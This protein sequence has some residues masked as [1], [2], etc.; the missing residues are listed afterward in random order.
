M[1]SENPIQIARGLIERH[2]SRAAAVAQ[3]H[4]EVARMA[5]DSAELQR[6]NQVALAV[7]QLR[8]SGPRRARPTRH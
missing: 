1:T 6:W 5:G 4:L 3:E 2:Q 7:E 8:Q